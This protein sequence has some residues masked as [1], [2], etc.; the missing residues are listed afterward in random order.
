MVAQSLSEY[1]LRA[2]SLAF[3]WLERL[4]S[5]RSW[6][7][8]GT[9]LTTCVCL[10]LAFPSYQDLHPEPSRA[11]K[12]WQAVLMKGEDLRWNVLEKFGPSTNAARVNFRLTGP[13]LVQVF[14]LGI[15]EL[16][17]VQ[18]AAGILLLAISHWLAWRL[19]GDRAAALLFAL[20]IG[21]TW[22]GATAFCELRGVFDGVA[23]CLLAAALAS[24]NAL[25]T[26]ICVFLAAWT[27]ERA[28]VA[29]PLLLSSLWVVHTSSQSGEG[30]KGNRGRLIAGAIAGC[31]LHLVSRFL[32]A[33]WARIPHR[34]DGNGLDVLLN[35]INNIPMGTWAGLEGGWILVCSAMLIA[36]AREKKLWVLSFAVTIGLVLLVGHCVVDISR[37]TAFLLPALFG[38]LAVLSATESKLMVRRVVFLSSVVSLLWPMY[39][40]GGKSTIWWVYPLPIQLIRLALGR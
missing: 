13:L 16:V 12:T 28:L 22:A 25:L 1:Y 26:M 15:P 32:Y 31:G 18:A 20:G 23:L 36:C 30:N 19:C 35:Q 17:A 5:R 34:F 29:F 4:T 40:V 37:T 7:W 21:A 14:Q 38:G 24:P 39:Y 2:E 9:F 11:G 10:I 27:D 3:E 6:L 8:T 33:N